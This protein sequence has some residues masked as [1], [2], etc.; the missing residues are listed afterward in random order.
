MERI[1]VHTRSEELRGRS[2]LT[3]RHSETTLARGLEA[4]ERVVLHDADGGYRSASV[5]EVEVTTGDVEY[6]LRLGVVLPD[7]LAAERIS[8]VELTRD[9]QGIHD[10][11]DLIGELRRLVVAV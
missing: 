3:V 9:R 7:D 11:V 6:L 8:G 10:V 4:A 2:Y 5:E 1:E